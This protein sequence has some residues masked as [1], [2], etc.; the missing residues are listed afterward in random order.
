MQNK[1]PGMNAPY[2]HNDCNTLIQARHFDGVGS[3]NFIGA[4]GGNNSSA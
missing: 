1:P 3:D 2:K 4:H